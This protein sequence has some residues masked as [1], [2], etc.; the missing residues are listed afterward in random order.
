MEIFPIHVGRIR[1][2]RECK[3]NVFPFSFCRCS[4]FRHFVH[5]FEAGQVNRK[6]LFNSIVVFS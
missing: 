5:S 3:E 1:L 4:V 2:V 6:P